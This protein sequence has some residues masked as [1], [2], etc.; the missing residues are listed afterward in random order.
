[1]RL[2]FLPLALLMLVALPGMAFGQATGIL[3]VQANV[4][5]AFVLLDGEPVGQ[6][7]FL[8]IIEAGEYELTVT[9]DGFEDYVETI[10]LKADT[11]LEVRAQLVRIEPG[12]EVTVDVDGAVVALDGEQIGT[13]RKVLMDPAPR[14]KH[15]LTVES[16]AYGTW[17]AEV[18][19]NPGVV[20]PVQV[21]LRGSLG[22]ISVV[23]E[24]AK[25][26]V[27]LD[28]EDKGR[29]PVVI[30]PVQPGSHGLRIE[31]RGKS[32]V[33]EQVVVDAGQTVE[34]EIKLV[35]EAGSLEVKPSVSDA[36]VLVNGVD[37]G[38][39]KVLL[40][41]IKPGSYS[42]RVTAPDHT[43]FIKSVIVERDQK[44]TLVA[45]L[46]SFEFGGGRNRRLAG[47]PPKTGNGDPITKKPG[48][49]AAIGGGVGAAIAVGIIAGAASADGGDPGGDPGSPPTPGWTPP[50]SD[51]SLALP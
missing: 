39:G 25:A 42:V 41:N 40:E 16:E 21:N 28:G 14:G 36:K 24:P 51:I 31:R 3:D 10:S 30:E 27:T 2:R 32:I 38:M 22:S 15:E 49:W 35:D 47:G 8:E 6:I 12:L 44:A 17:R 18:T 45:K 43:D 5:D 37:V 48:F 11:S 33:L 1:M 19:L 29:T 50:T 34:R 9:R 23:T 46:E 7:P 4:E 26:K 20:T 13:G